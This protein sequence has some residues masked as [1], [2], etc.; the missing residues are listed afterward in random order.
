MR[1]NLK[2]YRLG[3]KLLVVDPAQI[4]LAK[5]KVHELYWGSV[6]EYILRIVTTPW[7]VPSARKGPRAPLTLLSRRE[8]GVH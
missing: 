8:G 2:L 7:I 3:G 4:N 5:P 6:Q 1:K